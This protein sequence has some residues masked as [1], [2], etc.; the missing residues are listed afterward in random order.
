[1][2]SVDTVPSSNVVLPVEC[3]PAETVLSHQYVRTGGVGTGDIKM[4]DL[5]LLSVATFG[6]Q[7]GQNN[8]VGELWVSYDIELLK[9]QLSLDNSPEIFFASTTTA[10][11]SLQPLGG[12]A[13]GAYAG[14]TMQGVTITGGNTINF[15]SLVGP[16][17]QLNIAWGGSSLVTTCPAPSYAGS[18]TPGIGIVPYTSLYFTP[19]GSTTAEL[20]FNLWFNV[21]TT[22]GTIT[23]GAAGTIPVTGQSVLFITPVSPQVPSAA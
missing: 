20:F 16:G 19:N 21:G 6:G 10:S 17:Y 3:A 12:F 7:T 8:V 18:V 22:G 23:F 13:V 1:M 4:F 5:G 14:N 2:W 15:S 11:T 9:P